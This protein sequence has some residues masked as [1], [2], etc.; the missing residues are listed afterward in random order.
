MFVV[1]DYVLIVDTN[2]CITF[3]VYNTY[4]YM[5]LYIRLYSY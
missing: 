5:I 3:A 4:M 1:N 2:V